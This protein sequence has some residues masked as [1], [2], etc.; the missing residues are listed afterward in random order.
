MIYE[1]SY[2]SGQ[3][4]FVADI[5]RGYWSKASDFIYAGI[6]LGFRLDVFALSWITKV[7]SGGKKEKNLHMIV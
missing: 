4:P 5:K 2:E 1:S 3:R 7:E 6:S